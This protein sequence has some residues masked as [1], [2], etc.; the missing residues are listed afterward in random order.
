LEFRQDYSASRQ[1]GA[2]TGDTSPG[3]P[4]PSR[5]PR[6][7]HLRTPGYPWFGVVERSG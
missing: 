7:V 6:P 1:A 2:G 5:L 3:L 4:F